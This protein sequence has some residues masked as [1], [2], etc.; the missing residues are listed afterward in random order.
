MYLGDFA[1]GKTF[2]FKFTTR[3]FTTGAPTQ[4]AGTPVISAYPDNSTTQLTAGI[5]LTVDFDT[6]TG[7]NNVR[8]VATG[9]NGYATA[10][11]YALV[12]TTGTVGGVSVVGEV[13]GHFSI[14]AR[15]A[16][17]PATADRTLVVD[18]AGLADANTVKV[19][20]TGSGTAQTAGDIIG[21]T[22]D[23]Q[24]RLPAALTADG[25]IKADTLRVGG[26]LQ[27]AGDII[28]DTNDIQSRLPAALTGGKME[29]NIGSITA[30]VI[31]AA[32]FAA[33]A[34]DAVWTVA[35]RT[36]TAFGFGVTVTT[37][38]DKTDYSLSA[39]GIQ[40]IWDALT[41]ALT[42]VGSIG[43][44]LIDRLDAAI[45]S[46]STFNN[47]VD[48]VIVAT[49]NDKTGY[50]I[51][52]GGIGSTAFAANAIDA[53][54]LDPS[55]SNEIAD[56]ILARDLQG[57]SSASDRNVRNSLRTN[58]NRVVISSGGSVTVYEEDD[59]TPAW[60]GTATRD[61]AAEPITEILPT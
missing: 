6:V 13:V 16:L 46:R 7:L 22:N 19:G 5:T 35:T 49:N 27:T 56:S 39:A 29:S 52:V 18:A 51:G 57:G 23:I 26:T 61:A 48:Q 2:D 42:T 36:L 40:A 47:A 15:S 30:G 24:S 12:I 32:S 38:N 37:N 25:N 53:A 1:L 4:L 34:F 50:S 14:E 33:G 54:A 17:R 3:S 58:R 59:T 20:P 9:G 44:F 11:N 28:G 31:A 41:A 60:T 8:V 43:K 55:A 21:D 10:T 45:S